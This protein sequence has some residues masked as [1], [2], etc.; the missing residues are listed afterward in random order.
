M[1]A[2]TPDGALLPSLDKQSPTPLSRLEGNGVQAI[3]LPQPPEELGGITGACHH[4]Q[5][6]FVFLVET[7]FH[8]VG[9][10]GPELLT[11]RSLALS[12][13]WSSVARSRLTAT[14]ASQVQAILL[15]Q[16]P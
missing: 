13:G 16:L 7:E 9:Q 2:A 6:I 12:P 8:L 4:A 3:L 10:A 5:L 1:A 11:L 15:P 14:S